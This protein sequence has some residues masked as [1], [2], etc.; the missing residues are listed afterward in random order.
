MKEGRKERGKE[1]KEERRKERK[2]GRKDVGELAQTLAPTGHVIIIC[3]SNSR[4]S[5][6][7][8]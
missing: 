7:L 2:K 1:E 6:A 4:G 3:N 8:F 5:Y